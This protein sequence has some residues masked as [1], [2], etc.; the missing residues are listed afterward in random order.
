M[1]IAKFAMVEKYANPHQNP[2]Y[3]VS[4]SWL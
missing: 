1:I 2:L 4:Q 3:T